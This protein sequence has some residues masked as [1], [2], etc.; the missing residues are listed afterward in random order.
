MV[1]IRNTT[2][3][4]QDHKWLIMGILP[5]GEC[6]NEQQFLDKEPCNY[7]VILTSEKSQ[8]LKLKPKDFPHFNDE[9][10]R[11]QLRTVYQAKQ[12]LYKRKKRKLLEMT[13][14]DLLTHQ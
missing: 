12:R 14:E 11:E 4:M 5:K 1:F 8:V 9:H 7:G 2:K 3:F 6:F 10:T 13:E